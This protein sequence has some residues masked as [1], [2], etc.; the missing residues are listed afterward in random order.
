MYLETM[1]ADVLTRSLDSPSRM[2]GH[3]KTQINVFSIEIIKVMNVEIQIV[4]QR[5]FDW[6][7]GRNY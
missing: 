7:L 3:F 1:T 4:I 6:G 2:C 5:A